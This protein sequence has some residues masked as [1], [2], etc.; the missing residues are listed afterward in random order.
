MRSSGWATE[1][2]FA[3]PLPTEYLAAFFNGG[4]PTDYAAYQFQECV[5]RRACARSL[6]FV[7][8]APPPSHSLRLARVV[9]IG[10][11]IVIGRDDVAIEVPGV[12]RALIYALLD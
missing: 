10:D 4:L 6:L 7:P 3:R 8:P 5:G 9:D 11:K 12:S 2:H 1:R